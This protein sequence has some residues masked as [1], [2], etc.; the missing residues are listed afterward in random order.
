MSVTIGNIQFSRALYDAEVDVLYLHVGDPADA[1]DFDASEEGHALRYGE[2][3]RLV[4]LTVLNARW[5]LDNRGS[6][7][8]TTPVQRLEASRAD[9]A[10]VLESPAA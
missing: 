9:L 3:D 2:G 8:I 5:L 6:V 10:S 7:V 4:G 1:V